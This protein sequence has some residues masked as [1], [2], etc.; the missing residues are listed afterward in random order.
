MKLE[1]SQGGED[2]EGVGE[3]KQE[4]MQL[5]FTAYTL[6]VF[7]NEIKNIET[8]LGKNSMTILLCLRE[9]QNGKVENYQQGEEEWRGE[10]N[11]PFAMGV[12]KLHSG[13]GWSFRERVRQLRVPGKIYLVPASI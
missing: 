6:D 10:E 9:K 11:M 4:E 7:K 13:R 5:N 3:K 2:T 1:G 12:G 8:D